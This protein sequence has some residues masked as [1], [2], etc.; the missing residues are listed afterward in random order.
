MDSLRGRRPS[1]G[2]AR[3]VTMRDLRRALLNTA[4]KTRRTAL[5]LG[6]AVRGYVVPQSTSDHLI[7]DEKNAV[8]RWIGGFNNKTGQLLLAG[9]LLCALPFL[10][11][12]L[13]RTESLKGWMA[14]IGAVAIVG[15]RL[16]EALGRVAGLFKTDVGSSASDLAIVV[17]AGL[18]FPVHTVLVLELWKTISLTF[19]S[20]FSDGIVKMNSDERGELTRQFNCLFNS[21]AFRVVAFI[22]AAV[23][24]AWLLVSRRATSSWWGGTAGGVLGILSLAWIGIVI[25]YQLLCHNLKGVVAAVLAVRMFRKTQLHPLLLHEDGLWGL[26]GVVRCCYLAFATSVIHTL[27]LLV[28]WQL[29]FMPSTSG[30]FFIVVSLFFVV[31][32]PVFVIMPLRLLSQQLRTSKRTLLRSIR[33]LSVEATQALDEAGSH[34]GERSRAWASLERLTQLRLLKQDVLRSSDS[35]FGGTRFVLGVIGYSLQIGAALL[36]FHQVFVGGQVR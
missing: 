3:L 7:L 12:I 15:D 23:F 17:L 28:M 24:T 8:Y 18:L 25:W 32:F 21:G 35:A 4:A 10:V 20:L 34:H 13:S 11:S 1:F 31:F 9:G 2:S 33:V 26:S 19:T 29:D 27:A 5:F 36:A 30:S 6:R 14:S 16:S 22:G